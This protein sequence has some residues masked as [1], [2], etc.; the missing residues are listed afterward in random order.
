MT[1]ALRERKE[2]ERE[3]K[4]KGGCYM[5]I[6]SEVRVKQWQTKKHHRLTDN[7]QKLGRWKERSYPRDFRESMALLRLWTSSL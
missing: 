2:R 1:G 3:R 6:N 5:T 4:K 7:H